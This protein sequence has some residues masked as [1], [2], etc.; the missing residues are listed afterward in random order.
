MKNLLAGWLVIIALSFNAS[1]FEDDAANSKKLPITVEKA[2]A[3]LDAF[4]SQLTKDDTFSGTILWAKDDTVLY[5][6][7]RGM[8]S[9]RFNVANN[10]ETK[11]NLASLNK[12]FTATAIM[13]LVEAN[14]LS[15][16]DTLDTFVDE[17]WLPQVL[18]N[19]IQIQHLLTHSSGLGSYFTDE[20]FSTSKTRFVELEDFKPIVKN[21][22]L[23]FEPGTG[24]RYS[25]NGMLLL[26]VVIEVVTDTSYF[27]HIDGAIYAPAGMQNSGCFPRS[28]PIQNLA[29]GYHANPEKK[30]GWETNYLWIADKGGPAGGCY[31]NVDDMHGFAKALTGNILLNQKNTEAMYASK[32]EF[33]EKSY[34]YGFKISGAPN[35]RIVGHRGG[36]IG[37][38]SNLDIF[39]DS[40]YVSVVLSN[41]SGGSIPVY[42]K[43]RDLVEQ[44]EAHNP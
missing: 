5:K 40:G 8:A 44:L 39:L 4:I 16:T 35:N 9:K 20:F 12:M 21:D 11:F 15:L 23:E 3:E 29:V 22:T 18:S 42:E 17:S 32:P 24:Y 28:Q 6:S 13:R 34:G 38:S 10:L 36:F 31:S 1:S 14:Q 27:D 41:H 25:N 43:I 19:K 26:G 7:A 37:M 30:T 33:H 2:V